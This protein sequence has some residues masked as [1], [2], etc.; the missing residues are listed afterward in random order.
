MNKYFTNFLA[1]GTL[2]ALNALGQ[3]T[4]TRRLAI[5]LMNYSGIAEPE[6]ILAE[7]EAARI[8]DRAGIRARWV[9]CPTPAE[10][11][12]D[13]SPE[14]QW[15]PDFAVL[16]VQIRPRSMASGVDRWAE[17]FG[18]SLIPK[19]GLGKYAFVYSDGATLLAKEQE[20][21]RPCMLGHLVAHEI[22]HLLLGTGRHSSRGIMRSPWNGADLTRAMQG[23]L[24][25]STQESERIRDNVRKRLRAEEAS[26]IARLAAL[27]EHPVLFRLK[28][29]F[30]QSQHGLMRDGYHALLKQER[31]TIS[32]GRPARNYGR[33]V[34]EDS[35]SPR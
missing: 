29:F 35:S 13:D 14:C 27:N 31:R 22:G 26:D 32:S 15:L 11:I 17:V 3:E 28:T 2:V 24:L 34:A 25:F 8:L 5:W 23:R 1:L 9:H 20:S 19:N 33:E 30:P 10:Q 18:R 16:L 12:D 6:L 4:P 7:N 21:E